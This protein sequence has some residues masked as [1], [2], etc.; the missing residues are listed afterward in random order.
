MVIWTFSARND[1]HK[2]YSYIATDSLYYAKE[3][4]DKLMDFTQT[5]KIF[6]QKGRI[7]PELNNKNIRELL[8]YSY[9]IIYEIKPRNIYILT[10]LHM[11]R[12]FKTHI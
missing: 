7:V 8:F 1:L 9:R 10:I 6:P 12:N 2:L 4:I 11:K 5:L 3:V